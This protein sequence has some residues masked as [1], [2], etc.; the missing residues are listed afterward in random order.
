MT[1]ATPRLAA[2]AAAIAFATASG[3]APSQYR[4]WSSRS[5]DPTVFD[6]GLIDHFRIGQRHESVMQ[7]AELFH[8]R[9]LVYVGSGDEPVEVTFRPH[10]GLGDLVEEAAP[11][12]DPVP[13]SCDVRPQPLWRFE[14]NDGRLLAITHVKV[15][16]EE[17]AGSES[18]DVLS[19]LGRA[20][21]KS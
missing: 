18:V 5:L 10:S 2:I 11:Q 15:S 16:S 17:R 8:L 13:A 1:F 12:V 7:T 14:F 21:T 20:A 3:C 19:L 6:D 9:P 4:E